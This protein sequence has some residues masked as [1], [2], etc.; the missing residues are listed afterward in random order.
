MLRLRKGGIKADATIGTAHST[1]ISEGETFTSIDL[2]ISFFRPVWESVLS[3]TEKQIQHGKTI[4]HYQCE[5]TRDDGKVVALAMGT[6]MPLRG[7]A[8]TGR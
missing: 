6:V 3:A 1:A 4:T 8:A 2:K 5:F 7:N